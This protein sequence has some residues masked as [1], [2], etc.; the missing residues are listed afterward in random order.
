MAIITVQRFE[1]VRTLVRRTIPV[2]QRV[3]GK[4]DETTFRMRYHYARALYRDAGASLDDVREAVTTLQD[5]ERTAR[6]VFGSA[7]PLTTGF[8]VELQAAKAVLSARETTP[9]AGAT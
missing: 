1:E 8:E 5:T 4:N 6:R 2:A 3:L 7:H 9:P